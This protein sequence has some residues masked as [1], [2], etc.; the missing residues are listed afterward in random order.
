MT[1]LYIKGQPRP[2]LFRES[3]DVAEHAGL[4]MT[5]QH[6]VGLFTKCC[7]SPPARPAVPKYVIK[8]AFLALVSFSEY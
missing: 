6:D 2:T 7:S 5:L 1:V 4:R 8:D 3:S